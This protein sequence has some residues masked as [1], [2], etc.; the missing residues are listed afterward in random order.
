MTSAQKSLKGQRVQHT[1]E[2]WRRYL[3]K[4]NKHTARKHNMPYELLRLH[5]LAAPDVSCFRFTISCRFLRHGVRD[6]P[7]SCENDS[8]RLPSLSNMGEMSARAHP[9]LHNP[10]GLSLPPCASLL[11]PVC[12]CRCC[13]TCV[14]DVLQPFSI[15]CQRK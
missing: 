11:H 12:I 9:C 5:F 7:T 1:G 3:L 13:S 8:R 15:P 14:C 10:W 4:G 2:E 6:V